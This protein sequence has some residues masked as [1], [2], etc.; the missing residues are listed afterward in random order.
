M[1]D[2]YIGITTIPSRMALLPNILSAFLNQSYKPKKVFISIPKFSERFQ[3]EYKI[4][5]N[6]LL[7]IQQHNDFMEIIRCEKDYGP[8]TKLLG[9]F[10]HV[11]NDSYILICDDDRFASFD[12]V[13]KFH[14][15]LIEKEEPIRIIAGRYACQPGDTI[16]TPWGCN[17]ILFPKK[18]IDSDILE[19]YHQLC[20]ECQFVDDVFWYK[21]FIDYKKIDV[22]EAN[23]VRVSFELNGSNALYK[24]TG[25][26]ERRNLQKQCFDKKLKNKNNT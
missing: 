7:F 2:I 18:V 12:F 9:C 21:Y 16:K 14:T 1:K 26:L 3:Q 17:G 24:E 23:G 10:Q 5:K 4:P 20:P 25:L 6:L 15:T 19:C 13:E 22:E 8:A 11:P